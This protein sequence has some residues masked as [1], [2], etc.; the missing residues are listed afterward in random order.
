MEANKAAANSEVVKILPDTNEGIDQAEGAAGEDDG[1]NAELPA[2]HRDQGCETEHDGEPV[3]LAL[4]INDVEREPDGEVQD[5]AD[6]GSGH[7]GE[8]HADSS[9]A[10]E[11][12]DVR[13]AEEDPE[14]TGGERDPGGDKSAEGRG[15][16]GR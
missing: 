1:D 16:D 7:G 6:D 15:H 13:S 9:V 3:E 14:K 8:G 2:K 4:R 5:D 10:A 12:L 11:L